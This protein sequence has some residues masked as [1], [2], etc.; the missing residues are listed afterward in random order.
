MLTS[1]PLSEECNSGLEVYSYIKERLMKTKKHVSTW[2]W[3]TATIGSPGSSNSFYHA[4]ISSD[5]GFDMFPG[6]TEE[7]I[8]GIKDTL[9]AITLGLTDH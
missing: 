3:D 1:T 8:E 7:D 5:T 2:V 6:C 9:V 4:V